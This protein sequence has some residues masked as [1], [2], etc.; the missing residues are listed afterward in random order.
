MKKLSVLITTLIATAILISSSGITYAADNFPDIS[1]NTFETYITN[2]SDDEIVGGFK[3]GKYYPDKEVTRGQLS[4]FV[5]LAFNIETDTSCG[6]F[7][8]VQPGHT[9][10]EH[11]T[12]LK[13]KG[14]VGGYEDNTYK[15][16][17]GVTREQVTKFISNALNSQGKTVNLDLTSSFPDVPSTNK[18]YGYISFLTK[19]EAD[20][21]SVIKGYPSGKYEPSRVLTRGEMSKIVDIARKADKFPEVGEITPTPSPTLTPISTPTPVFTRPPSVF[22]TALVRSTAFDGSMNPGTQYDGY[23]LAGYDYHGWELIS[24]GLALHH[25]YNSP[26]ENTIDGKNYINLMFSMGGEFGSPKFVEDC[27]DI[28]TLIRE[29]ST[30]DNNGEDVYVVTTLSTTSY[31]N[32]TD[33]TIG[34]EIRQQLTHENG[35]VYYALYKTVGYEA[36]KNNSDMDVYFLTI[37]YGDSDTSQEELD[38]LNDIFDRFGLTAI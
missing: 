1:G 35:Y 23:Y 11:I 9:F 7:S 28:A 3:D 34:C 2:L 22:D 29:G 8:D 4:K 33:G 27:T 31:T 17:D 30:D 24:G 25:I 10:Y 26:V 13:C 14:I 20:G 12:T 37:V 18:F 15:P 38:A 21:V 19:V 32:S 6:D 36:D 5:K 16:D